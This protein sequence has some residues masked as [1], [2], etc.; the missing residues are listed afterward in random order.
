[1]PSTVMTAP[2]FVK[3]LKCSALERASRFSPQT[4]KNECQAAL[5]YAYGGAEDKEIAEEDA[6]LVM[7]HEE[8]LCFHFFKQC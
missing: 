2:G 5:T 3:G 8:N 7:L 1:M 4:T 6:R